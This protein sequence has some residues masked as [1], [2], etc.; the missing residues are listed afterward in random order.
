MSEGDALPQITVELD[1]NLTVSQNALQNAISEV[2]SEVGRALSNIDVLALSNPFFIRKDIDD[3]ANGKI[4][5]VKGIKFGEGGKVEVMDNNSAKLTIEYLEVTKKASFTSLEIKEKTHVGGQIVISPA[6]MTCGEVEELDEVY[7]CYFQTKGADGGDEIFNQFAIND[8]AICQTYNSWGG[9]YYWRKVV[10]IGEDYIDLSKTLCDEDSDIPMAG[11]KIVQLGNTEDATR[12]AAQVLSAYGEDAPSFIMYNG[13]NDFS[14]ADKNITGIAWN[15]NTLEPQMYS[16][17]SFFFGDRELNDNFITFQKK[18]GDT[19]KTLTINADVTIGANSSGLTNLAEW[20]EKQAQIDAATQG[21]T[22]VQKDIQNIQDQ[23]DGVVENHFYEG[24]P[25][26]DNFP[27]IQWTTE[28]DKANHIGDTYVNIASEEQDPDN[29]GKAWRWA[30]TD[31]EHTGYH[32]HPIADTDAVKALLEAYKAQA[33]IDDLQYLKGTFAKSVDVDGVVMS[34]MVAVKDGDEIK[35]FLNGSD[36]GKDSQ[37]GKLLIAAGV[38]DISDP[39]TSATKIYED[40]RIE[41]DAPTVN[42]KVI[43]SDDGFTYYDTSGSDK[44][45][46]ASMGGTCAGASGVFIAHN[47]SE[48]DFCTNAAILAIGGDGTSAG[49][50]HGDVVVSGVLDARSQGVWCQ[51]IESPVNRTIEIVLPEDDGL[52]RVIR[53]P[54]GMIEGLRPK[55]RVLKNTAN[56]SSPNVLTHLDHSVFVNLTSGTCYI[57]LPQKPQDGQEYYIESRGANMSIK[58]YQQGYSLYSGNTAEAGY[59]VSQTGRALLR[60]KFYSDANLWVYS[61]LNRNS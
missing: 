16:Y 38:S 15:P 22:L 4:N 56:S 42:G 13:I 35:A 23:I 45:L 54:Y 8:L 51:K 7:R 49:N 5:F 55:T 33:G 43:I 11:D 12:Q 27:A 6:A 32:W 41:V 39:S 60:F 10:G 18:E 17:G 53:I 47:A 2:K 25:T 52:T 59:S 37:H 50:F 48:P 19:K 24:V 34:E 9:R 21:V 61:W 3:V 28:E 40:G 20:K 26:N 58:M 14:L 36:I 46:R 29:A 30:Y 1:E 57:A 31:N 44:K